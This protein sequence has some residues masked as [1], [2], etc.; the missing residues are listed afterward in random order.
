MSDYYF[1]K[2]FALKIPFCEE[3]YGFVFFIHKQNDWFTISEERTGAS[4]VGAESLGEAIVALEQKM[5][6]HPP[7]R[8]QEIINE[9]IKEN[10]EAP[11][12]KSVCHFNI[13][14]KKPQKFQILQSNFK[15]IGFMKGS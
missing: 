8:I 12:I 15:T 6:K 3:N 9:L 13:S 2:I 5:K 1:K 11:K 10:G 7:Y 14:L 4:I